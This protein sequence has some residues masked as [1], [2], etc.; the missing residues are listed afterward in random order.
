MSIII[1]QKRIGLSGKP[2]SVKVRSLSQ[3]GN[4][5]VTKLKISVVSAKP[6]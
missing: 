2:S 6:R 4:Y 5:A 3:K 1:S